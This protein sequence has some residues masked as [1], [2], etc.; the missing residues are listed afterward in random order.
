MFRFLLKHSNVLEFVNQRQDKSKEIRRPVES[1]IIPL[2]AFIE[3]NVYIEARLIPLKWTESTIQNIQLYQETQPRV[4]LDRIVKAEWIANF[5]TDS[6]SL[7]R[8][9]KVGR[10]EG[11]IYSGRSNIY[12][13]QDVVL[14]LKPN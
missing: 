7:H 1:H 4:K 8:T 2:F 10:R 9:L 11:T 5:R 6:Q 14:H 13:I 12:L 3:T